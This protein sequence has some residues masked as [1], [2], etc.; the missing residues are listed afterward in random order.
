MNM[1]SETSPTGNPG[2]LSEQVTRL[3]EDNARL[4]NELVDMNLMY[5]NMM[6]HGVAIEDQLA[7]RNVEL[8]RMQKRLANELG[9]AA[10]YVQSL[11]PAPLKEYPVTQWRYVPSSELGGDS[12]GYHWIDPDHFAMYLLDVCGHG[13]GAALLSVTAINV[14]QS[15]TLRSADMRDP[16]QVLTGMNVTFEMSKQNDMYFTLWYGVFQRSTRILKFATGG[17]PPALLVS[18]VDGQPRVKELITP[19][20]VIGGMPDLTYKMDSC[21]VPPDGRLFIFSDGTYEI[22]KHGQPDMLTLEDYAQYLAKMT[23][24]SSYSLDDLI[25]DLRKV[26]GH[27]AFEDD[28]SIFH[29]DL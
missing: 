10:N 28:F 12:F 1:S 8:E 26:Q 25:A 5:E 22:R 11:I 18:S 7:D 21:V 24:G 13:V 17:H 15:G 27:D 14:L 2:P 29:V 23:R 4:Q 16:G 20:M 19:Q 9:E 6:E 3:Q